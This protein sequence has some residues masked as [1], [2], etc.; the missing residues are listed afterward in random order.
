MGSDLP[1]TEKKPSKTLL[2]WAHSLG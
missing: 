1:V 2:F